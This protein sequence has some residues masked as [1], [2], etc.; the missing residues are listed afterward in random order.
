M[1]Q[2]FDPLLLLAL[3]ASGKS[4]VRTYLTAKDPSQFHMGP[5]VQLDDYPYVH[6]MRR[7]SQELRKRGHDGVLFDSEVV[8]DSISQKVASYLDKTVPLKRIVEEV[9]RLIGP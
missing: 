8:R 9:E 3:P 7:I 6:V 2:I 4:E 1:S 5:N